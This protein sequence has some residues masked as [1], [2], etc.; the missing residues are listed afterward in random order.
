[1]KKITLYITVFLSYSVANMAFRKAVSSWHEAQ[2]LNMRHNPLRGW[3]SILLK[4]Y[5]FSLSFFAV[6][7]AARAEVVRSGAILGLATY[8]TFDFVLYSHFEGISLHFVA[9]N[10][11]WGTL[12]SAMYVVTAVYVGL[13][14]HPKAYPV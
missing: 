2:L 8:G 5:F 10:L 11:T 3:I 6:F 9:M 7:P 14:L 13:A 12:T 4:I 1:M